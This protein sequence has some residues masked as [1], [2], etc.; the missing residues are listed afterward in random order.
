MLEIISL[1]CVDSTQKYLIEKIKKGVLHPPILIYTNNQ[2]A[3]IGS[4]GNRWESVESGLYFSFA[5]KNS[6]IPKELP[7]Q[8]TSIYFGML[9][10]GLLRE[11]GSK[12]YLKWPN[13]IYI[14]KK[15]LGGII[16]TFFGDTVVSGIGLNIASN[17]DKIGILDI[18]ITQIELLEEYTKK[19][20]ERISWKQIFINFEVEFE[21]S[22]L[23]EFT[24]NSEKIALK[25]AKLNGDGSIE[26]GGSRYYSLR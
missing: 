18:K 7:R 17:N 19:I 14:D 11:R 10:I 25:D 26:I 16:T 1:E 6:S 24:N 4:R 23:H 2:F 3:G 21:K 9:L 22:K 13:D 8:S 12:A 15:K 5:L 20:T